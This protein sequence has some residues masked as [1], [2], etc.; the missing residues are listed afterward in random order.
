MVYKRYKGRRLKPGHKEWNKGKWVVEFMLKGNRVLR[1][2]PHARNKKEAEEEQRKIQSQIDCGIYSSKS[3]LFSEFVDNEYLPWAE[4]NK[5]SHADDRRRA[6]VLK[7]FFGNERLRNIAPYRIEK[8]KSSLIGVK[9]VRGTPRSEP[10][11]NR[12]LALGSRIFSLARVNGLVQTNPF[13]HVR[14][15][16]EGGK[17]ERYLTYDEEARLMQVLVGDLE[18][19]H[20]PVIVS[21]GT[22]LRKSE[23]LSLKAGEINFEQLPIFYRVNGRDLAIRPG[24]LLVAKSKNKESR[25]IPMN[26]DVYETLRTIVADAQPSDSVFT[27]SRNGVSSSTIKSGFEVAC[28]RAEIT[29]G[30]TRV[31]GLTW[32]GLRHTFATRLREQG[33]H[34]FDIKELMGHKT[35]SVTANY[36]HGTPEAMRQ[37]VNRLQGTSPR[38]I[39]FRAAG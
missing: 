11:I 14:K 39:K 30:L 2:V 32:H 23:L 8:F 27:F 38:V 10:T 19:L 33:V 22:G 15:F 26:P 3:A 31:G 5:K 36:A 6:K 20:A 21:L 37:A 4:A 24:C 13:S 7:N 25:V 18:F 17:R 35:L 1:A 9:T 28:N 34:P 29:Y 12:Y 16:E